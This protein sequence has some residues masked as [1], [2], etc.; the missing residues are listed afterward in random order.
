MSAAG[1]NS[2]GATGPT[3]SIAVVGRRRV[4]LSHS[5]ILN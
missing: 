1:R 3:Q 4:E 2:P 5:I